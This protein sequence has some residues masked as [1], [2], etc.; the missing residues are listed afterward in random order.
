MSNHNYEFNQHLDDIVRQ[1]NEGYRSSGLFFNRSSLPRPNRK[2]ILEII[3]DF[4]Q[5]LF[6]TSYCSETLTR[7]SAPYFVGHMLTSLHDKLLCQLE[8]ALAYREGGKTEAVARRAKEVSSEVFQELPRIQKLLFIDVEAALN[9][10]P[11]AGSREQVIFSYPGLNA[12]FVHRIAHE[13]YL[14]DIPYIPRIM[15]EYV[16]GLTG[17]DINPGAT[18]GEYFFIDHGTGVVIGETTEIGENVKIYQ[19]VTLGALSTRAGLKLAGKKRHPT[20][21]N[22]VTIYSGASI[23]G[24]K[25][26]IGESSTIGGNAYITSSIPPFSR[27]SIKNPELTVHDF[28]EREQE[29]DPEDYRW[30]S[31]D[32]SGL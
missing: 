8:L 12:I 32:H 23:L 5:L 22:N 30:I 20:I 15:S 25:T 6:P 14:R 7:T 24:G 28:G 11:A 4:R 16:H 18:I 27:V 26:V 13:L 31:L 29:L 10:D 3:S 9:G 19:G 21:E 17:I 1:L 2:V